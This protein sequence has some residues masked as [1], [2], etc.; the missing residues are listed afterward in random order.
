[1]FRNVARFSGILGKFLPLCEGNTSFPMWSVRVCQVFQGQNRLLTLQLN[2]PLTGDF[3]L[4]D[5]GQVRSHRVT[6]Q[7]RL[8]YDGFSS[9]NFSGLSAL[10]ICLALYI[11]RLIFVITVKGVIIGQDFASHKDE[12][13][14]S[15]VQTGICRKIV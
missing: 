9:G 7:N 14:Y 15:T 10:K 1:M 5:S 2:Q 4:F 3:F 8:S 12:V 11:F 13:L 6:C